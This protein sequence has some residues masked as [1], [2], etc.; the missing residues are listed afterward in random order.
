MFKEHVWGS[1]ECPVKP[2]REIAWNS[3]PSA[4][5][6][7]NNNGRIS[8]QPDAARTGAQRLAL[9]NNEYIQNGLFQW[10]FLKMIKLILLGPLLFFKPEHHKRLK[11]KHFLFYSQWFQYVWKYKQKHCVLQGAWK[12]AK[13]VMLSQH[14]DVQ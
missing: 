2:A 8:E 3:L 7:D 5:S 13:L 9:Y 1:F 14:L 11:L 4:L 10:L 6:V 12:Y